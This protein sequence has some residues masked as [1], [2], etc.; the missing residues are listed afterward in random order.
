MRVQILAR[1]SEALADA[2][3]RGELATTV[4]SAIET[5][6][7]AIPTQVASAEPEA[8]T[9]AAEP[10]RAVQPTPLADQTGGL[11]VVDEKAVIREDTGAAPPPGKDVG[12]RFLPAPVVQSEPVSRTRIFIQA[13][14]FASTDNANRLR[15]R[16][17]SFGAQ[18]EPVA[19][20]GQQ[21]YRVRVGP[22]ADVAGADQKLAQ[23][24]Q[25]GVPEAKIIVE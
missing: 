24:I 23:I 20:N 6:P 25:A 4:A 17:A 15:D 1:D 14:A 7:G 19:V 2:A 12:G 21:L 18:V 13:G 3:K 9:Q 8:V 16:L 11:A 22:L 5:N 10:S